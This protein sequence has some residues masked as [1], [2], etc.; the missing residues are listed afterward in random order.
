M[1]NNSIHIPVMLNEV[2]D[3]LNLQENDILIEGTAGFGG[4]TQAMLETISESGIYLGLDQDIT[5]ITHSKSLFTNKTYVHHYHDN[6]SNFDLYMSNHKLSYF[7]K[8]LLDLGISSHQ[9]DE[10]T[11]GFSHRFDGPLD[12]RMNITQPLDA[13]AVLNTYNETDLSNMFYNYGELRHNSKLVTNIINFRKESQIKTTTD[14]RNLIKKSYFFH[15]KR[16]LFMKTC[17]Q[18]FQAI[19][20]EVNQELSHLETVLSKIESFAAP[21][22]LIAIIT[23]HSLED[24][25]VKHFVKNSNALIFEPKGALKPSKEE[26]TKNARSRSAK[27]RIIKKISE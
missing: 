12:M 1:A 22:A 16:S 20:I 5:A 25:I 14:L 17:S 15:N 4:H 2:V 13:K 9:I 10:S 19:R 26:R 23:F 18:V 24:R 7:T 3:N 21:N 6:F 27:C 8:F 11:R